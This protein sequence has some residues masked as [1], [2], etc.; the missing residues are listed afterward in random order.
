MEEKIIERNVSEIPTKESNSIDLSLY[1]N[2]T[3]KIA[4]VHEV[5]VQDLY[6]NGEYNPKSVLTTHKIKIETEPLRELDEGNNFTDKPLVFKDDKGNEN[7]I[8]RRHYFGLSLDDDGNWFISK[9]PNAKLWKFMQNFKVTDP[10][11]LEGKY[12][13]LVWIP[14]SNP[15]EDTG[16]LRILV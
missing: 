1:H 2:K 3:V 5:E 10:K 6:P 9:H 4:K 16:K 15:E 13:K 7:P 14:S 8:T 11:Q 12:V